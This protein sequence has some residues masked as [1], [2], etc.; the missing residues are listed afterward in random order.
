MLSKFD[1]IW[2]SFWTADGAKDELE[3]KI[4]LSSLFLCSET[5]ARASSTSDLILSKEA[6]VVPADV[7]VIGVVPV[8]VEEIAGH[9][10][11]ST[12]APAVA[13]SRKQYSSS[14]GPPCFV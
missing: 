13:S 2:L 12:F 5:F 11:C 8:K 6:A 4:K 10:F 9:E 3:D 1:E 7:L 14:G